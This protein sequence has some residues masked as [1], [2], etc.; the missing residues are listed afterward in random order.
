MRQ[1]DFEAVAAELAKGRVGAP[2]QGQMGV[3]GQGIVFPPPRPGQTGIGAPALPLPAGMQQPAYY[4]VPQNPVSGA[5]SYFGLTSTT[6]ADNVINA[7]VSRS[8]KRIP[9]RE[10]QPL[11]LIFAS[12][13]TGILVESISINN[14]NFM[15]HSEGYGIPCEWFSEPSQAMGLLWEQIGTSNGC[16]IKL[17][18]TNNTPVQMVAGFAGIQMSKS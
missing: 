3:S 4:Y 16:T 7:G 18:N 5:N 2:W 12:R 10:F 11:Q 6:A 13:V 17:F 1:N 14:V 8:F 9:E 15:S